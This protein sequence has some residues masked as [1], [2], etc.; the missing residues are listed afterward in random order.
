MKPQYPRAKS[1]Y[2]EKV[3]RR[4]CEE[5]KVLIG[6]RDRQCENCGEE[7]GYSIEVMKAG[8]WKNRKGIR[9][10]PMLYLCAGCDHVQPFDKG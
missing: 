7:G 9:R 2:A 5:D 3:L 8:P 6:M 10:V 1:N 4:Q